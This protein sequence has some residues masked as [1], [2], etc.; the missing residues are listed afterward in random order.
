M[1]IEREF[2]YTESDEDYGG[3]GWVPRG[4]EKANAFEATM[5]GH[6]VMEHIGG[7]SDRY[8]DELLALGASV[9]V[10]TENGWYSMGRMAQNINETWQHLGSSLLMDV[11]RDA[12][13]EG[14][15]IRHPGRTRPLDAM[16]ESEF[17]MAIDY[18]INLA[19]FELD[20]EEREEGMRKLHSCRYTMLGW[21]RKGYRRAVRLY[22]RHRQHRALDAFIEMGEKLQR[23]TRDE[24]DRYEGYRVKVRLDTKTMKTTIITEEDEHED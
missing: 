18:C 22:G 19:K 20:S 10:R 6:D 7:E 5:I 13:Y 8:V 15:D 9:Y 3:A 2:V 11:F 16:Q 23:E 24:S 21:L 1:I 17:E 4:M 14:R 12:W